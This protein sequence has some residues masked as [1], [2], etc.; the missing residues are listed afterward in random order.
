MEKYFTVEDLI[1]NIDLDL[2]CLAKDYKDVK[3]IT[4]EVNRPG[5]QLVG[6]YQEFKESRLQ[7]IGNAESQYLSHLDPEKRKNRIDNYMKLTFPAIVVTDSNKIPKE[8]EE[9][10]KKADKTLLTTKASTSKFMND[11]YNFAIKKLAPK[12]SIHGVLIEIYGLGVLLTGKSGIGKSETALDL[13]SR[14]HRLIS[15][16]VVEITKVNDYLEGE[17]PELTRHFME[18]RGVGILDIERLYGVGAVKQTQ[19]IDLVI[20]LEN[21][22][23]DKSYDRLGLDET[24]TEILATNIPTISIPMKPGRNTAMVIEVASRNHIQKSLGYNAA[25]ELNNRVL[26]KIQKR[27][28]NN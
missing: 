12:I 28:K 9:A 20:E 16:D 5:L 14:G 19:V 2:V 13:V 26:E 23:T 21:W 3:I 8:L 4:S 7:L 18:L 6:F 25:I 1:N 27:K 17:S 24:Y 15:D 10:A 22:D 11:Y